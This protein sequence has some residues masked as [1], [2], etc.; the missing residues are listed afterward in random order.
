MGKWLFIGYTLAA[1]IL[2]S[3]FVLT[4]GMFRH[5]FSLGAVLVG[6]QFFKRWEEKKPRIWFIVLV[7]L[8]A[9]FLPLIYVF[10]AYSNGWYVDP[11]YLE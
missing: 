8:C 10:V 9:L 4:S 2:M 5:V 11:R 1:G 3:V 7:V 6:I